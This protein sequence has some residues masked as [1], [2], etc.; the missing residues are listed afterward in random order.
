MWSLLV[1]AVLPPFV[2]IIMQPKWPDWFR[3]VVSVVISIIA[4]FVTTYL[5]ID[6]ALWEQ[7]MVTSMLLVGVS[8]LTMYRNFW[9]PTTI[10][11]QIE[12]KTSPGSG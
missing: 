2:A 10:A 6:D 3:A 12:A 11:P 1:G 5:T 4:G 8:S 9:K 7:P